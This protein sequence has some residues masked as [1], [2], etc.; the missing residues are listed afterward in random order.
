M[1]GEVRHGGFHKER[2]EWDLDRHR[3][4]YPCN[5]SGHQQGMTAQLEEIIVEPDAFDSQD[6]RENA[7]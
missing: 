5:C 4:A 6:F 3:I 7:G 2:A 1:A